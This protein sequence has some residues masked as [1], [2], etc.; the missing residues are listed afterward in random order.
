MGS[1]PEAIGPFTELAHEYGPIVWN[2]LAANVPRD[3]HWNWLLPRLALALLI[4]LIRKGR[5]EDVLVK[6]RKG[7]DLAIELVES[8]VKGTRVDPDRQ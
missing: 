2:T 8:T 4:F 3:P 6:K 7:P 5:G 1:S